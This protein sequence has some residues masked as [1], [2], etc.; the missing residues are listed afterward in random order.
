MDEAA[1]KRLSEKGWRKEDLIYVDH[2]MKE[3]NKKHHHINQHLSNIS[4]WT[5]M[6]GVAVINVIMSI[7]I[8]PF[9][10]LLQ[11]PL[12]FL[13]A[14]VLGFLM[15]FFFKFLM[16]ELEGLEEEH[17]KVILLLVPVMALIDIFIIRLFMNWLKVLFTVDYNYDAAVFVFMIFFLAPYIVYHFWHRKL[18]E[19]IV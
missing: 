4:F 13:S 18:E 11:G 14:L 16:L 17:H 8:I 6:L 19:R 12:V 15:G 10:I 1:K 5:L 7:F 9:L 3:E 2:L